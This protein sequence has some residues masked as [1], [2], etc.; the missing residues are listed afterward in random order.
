M[1][2][3]LEVTEEL[4]I[5]HVKKQQAIKIDNETVNGVIKSM[6]SMKKDLQ[7]KFGEIAKE[8]SLQKNLKYFKY[9]NY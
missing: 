8:T 4:K 3:L 9:G 2:K 1:E 7:V 5:E 6:E